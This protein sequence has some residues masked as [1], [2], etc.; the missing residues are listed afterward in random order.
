MGAEWEADFQQLDGVWVQG[1]HE[2]E[3]GAGAAVRGVPQALPNSSD[4]VFRKV[5]PELQPEGT[6]DA[7]MSCLIRKL[8]CVIR[9]IL[10]IYLVSCFSSV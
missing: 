2:D 5:L 6:Y 3:L 8:L 7:T 10:I 4:G 1:G 9:I